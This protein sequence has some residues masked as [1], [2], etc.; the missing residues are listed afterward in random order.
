MFEIPSFILPANGQ[1]TPETVGRRRKMAETL[2]GQGIDTSPVQSPW[3][4]VGRIGQAAIGG[5]TDHLAGQQ[6]E[7]GR[8]S[9]NQ[10]MA[11]LLAMDDPGNGA[12]MAAMNN[13]W[14]TE[15]HGKLASL[16][17]EQNF[18][19]KQPKDPIKMGPEDVLLDP[20]NNYSVL[21]QGGAKPTDDIREYNFYVEQAKAAGQHPM[22]FDEFMLAMK[23]AGASQTTIDMK[24]QTEYA[25]ER[26]KGYAKRANEIDDA[27]A[28]AMTSIT[29]LGAME[30]AMNDPNFYSGSGAEIVQTLKRAAVAM[31]GDPNQ[32]SST[33]TFN[34]FAKQ[35][36]LATMGGSLGTGFSNA[37]R[38]FVEGQV[39]ILGNTPEGNRKLISIHRKMAE[40]KIQ[41]ARMAR[42]YEE[43]N[44]QIDNGFLQQ[45]SQWAEENPLFPQDQMQQQSDT[46]APPQVGATATNPQTGE[47]IIWD[48]AAWRPQ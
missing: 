4:A 17:M 26:G 31:G 33:E 27:E 21:H 47:R 22:A 45:L 25:K 14:L 39:P 24:G 19:K 6:E 13:P 30:Q 38:D 35:A 32:V 41:I 11:E 8:S 29:S 20:N 1:A 36:A 48:G 12:I 23:K 40:R 7:Q 2:M 9:A 15:G 44:G 42:E 34:S 43:A 5:Y 3:Q 16:L 37:D 10:A 46:N 18:K 28:A